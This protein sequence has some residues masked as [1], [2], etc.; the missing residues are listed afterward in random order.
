M[1]GS[2]ACIPRPVADRRRKPGD[3][4]ERCGL[5]GKAT[6]GTSGAT[7]RLVPASFDRFDESQRGGRQAM[8]GQPPQA[9]QS[10]V[11]RKP[12]G[13]RASA[14]PSTSD[15][16]LMTTPCSLRMR[17][18]RGADARR[19]SRLDG[20]VV[21]LEVGELFEILDRAFGDQ[22]RDTHVDQAQALDRERVSLPLEGEDSLTPAEADAGGDRR[23]LHRDVRRRRRRHRLFL[24][25]HCRRR[26]VDVLTTRVVGLRGRERHESQGDAHRRRF[27][28]SFP[29]P[30]R[31]FEIPESGSCLVSTPPAGKT[32]ANV[33]GASRFASRS[34]TNERRV[35]GASPPCEGGTAS[36]SGSGFPFHFWRLERIAPRS[37]RRRS[38]PAHGRRAAASTTMGGL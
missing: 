29:T 26:N 27:V 20:R 7:A 6:A 25:D 8:R 37:S 32:C 19:G 4:A 23:A 3:P 31:A 13:P 34:R 35:R 16:R 28:E 14:T 17:E 21:A 15:F 2:L 1:I 12:S 10:S 18:H 9:D 22:L 36:L 11:I 24:D 30:F 5:G 33:S 38:V